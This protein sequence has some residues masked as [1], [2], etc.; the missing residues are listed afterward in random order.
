M[1]ICGI[2]PGKQG[3]FVLIRCDGTSAVLRMPIKPDGKTVDGVAI[4]KW[5]L[6]QEV[7]HAVVEK[8]GARGHRN[9]Q[10]KAI[11]NAG[12]EFRFA[13]GIGVIHGCLDSMGIPYKKIMPMTWKP[14]VLR[15]LG[16]DKKAAIKYAQDFWPQ[17]DLQPGRCTTPHDGIADAVCLA[18]YGINHIK[19]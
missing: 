9:Q 14:K 13:I 10:G 11:R 7:T 12:N 1:N 19:W 15:E 16:L 17:V 3:A 5:L 4:S 8:I 18:D 2:D 6:E